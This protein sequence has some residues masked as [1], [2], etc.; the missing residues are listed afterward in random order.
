MIN[1]PDNPP[2]RSG[3]DYWAIALRRRWWIALP[4]FLCWF[5]IWGLSW[6]LPST[7]E[8]EAVILLEQQKVPDQYVLSNTTTSLQDR[9]QSISQQIL[10]R[11][12]LQETIDRFQ[13]YSRRGT[14]NFFARRR[15]PVDRMRDDIRLELVRAPGHPG[16]FTAFKVHYTAGSPELAQRVNNELT[17]LF[18]AENTQAQQQLSSD[19]TAF[20][21]N[22]LT[23]ARIKMEQQEA[24]VAAFKAKH[25]GELPSQLESN[26]QILSG[27]QGQL[28]SAH[29]ALDSANQQKLYLESLLQQYQSLR[30]NSDGG[31]GSTS[32]TSAQALE[33][34]LLEMRLRLQDLQTRYTEEHPD[35]VALK[36]KIAKAEHMQDPADSEKG[37]GDNNRIPT[38]A[39]ES[40]AR[41]AAQRSSAPAMMQ[42][43]SQLKANQLQILNIQQHVMDLESQI[44][45]YQA[46]LNLTPETEQELTSISRGYEES[47]ANYNSLLQKQMQSEL[48]TSLEQ[49][50]KGEQFR[51]V[52]PPSLPKRP[53]GPNH[54]RLSLGGLGMGLAL[55]LSLTAFLEWLDV[56]VRQEMDLEGIVPVRVLVGIPHLSTPR[57]NK[58]HAM[59]RWAEIGAAVGLV[60]MTALGNLYAVL[61]G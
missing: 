51:I 45:A 13:L 33:K 15:E 17:S 39:D 54:L 10:S 34:D 9:L 55:G 7:Y 29:Q 48:A 59:R 53:S 1:N 16:E 23:D 22:E 49:T 2:M 24:K 40:T 28:Q 32:P 5:A 41:I 11:T 25:L 20:L 50:Q 56:R 35:I 57:E 14:S 4:M 52:D 42:V 47:K 31:N 3:E 21:A 30:G 61:K 44:S 58:R 43:D 38:K 36:D 26:V 60:I 12:R 27:L 6:L 8:S 19:T 46:R 37:A 18:V